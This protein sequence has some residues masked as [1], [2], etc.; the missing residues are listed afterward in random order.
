MEQLLVG[1]PGFVRLASEEAGGIPR[2]CTAAVRPREAPALPP[3][4]LLIGPL[5][6]VHDT[7]GRV[8]RTLESRQAKTTR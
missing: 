1:L 2:L 7:A 8:R 5:P 4:P 6:S 3:I